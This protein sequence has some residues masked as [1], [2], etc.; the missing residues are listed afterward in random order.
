MWGLQL[1]SLTFEQLD[2]FLS[3]KLPEGNRLDYKVDVPKDL[4][5]IIAAFANTL[6]GLIVFGVEEEGNTTQPVWPPPPSGNGMEC[7]RGL[8]EQVLQ[9]ARDNIYPPVSIRISPVIENKHLAGKVLLVV[10]VDESRD[11]P[12][13]VEK[14]RE[15]YVYERDGSTSS[16][17]RLAEVDRIAA[18]L[19]RRRDVEAD[20][21]RMLTAEIER[22]RR[23]LN[24]PPQLRWAAVVPVYPWKAVVPARVCYRLH[25]FLPAFPFASR[26][27]N[28]QMPDGSY[29]RGV[30][31]DNQGGGRYT[32]C[33]RLHSKGLV[34]AME[35]ISEAD[36]GWLSLDSLARLLKR[37]IQA[38]AS[39]YTDK[40]AEQPGHVLISLGMLNVRHASLHS[41]LS[42]PVLRSRNPFLDED[43]RTER[44]SDLAPILSGGASAAAPILDEVAYSF[45]MPAAPVGFFEKYWAAF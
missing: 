16:P 45:D 22:G 8:R 3:T 4:P 10:R 39:V 32:F 17:Y 40:E 26:V 12:H 13:A 36:D 23:F 24:S 18:L 34:F 37:V 25:Q 38:A 33:S 11:A 31:D 9:I 44:F 43:Y 20:R 35:V 21:E 42:T 29:A 7:K 5:K 6:G 14:K 1:E 15:V 30:L 2:D 28:Q 19:H 27:V 41:V